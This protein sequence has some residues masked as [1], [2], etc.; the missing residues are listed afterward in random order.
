MGREA[1]FYIGGRWVDPLEPGK[2]IAVI[3]PATEEEVTRVA[4]ASSAEVE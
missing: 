1:Q 2:T 4:A 3:D